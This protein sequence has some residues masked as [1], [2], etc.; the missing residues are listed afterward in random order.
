MTNLQTTLHTTIQLAATMPDP[1]ATILGI[2]AADPSRFGHGGASDG[3]PFRLDTTIDYWDTETGDVRGIRTRTGIYD[4]AATWAA[5]WWSWSDDRSPKPS[6]D[7]LQWLASHLAWAERCY[8]AMTEFEEELTYVL[9]VLEHAHGLDPIVTDRT[10]P[11]CGGQLQHHVTDA[12]VSPEYDC[13]GCGNQYSSDG[14]ALMASGRAKAAHE[15]VTQ[16]EAARLLQISKKT[17]HS[18]IRRGHLQSYGKQS[19]VY[20]DEVRQLAEQDACVTA[21]HSA[22]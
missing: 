13:A 6:G 10:C 2:R 21:H 22:D 7:T 12:G 15:L 20:I 5:S 9:R 4:W 11:S 17:I 18:W 3:L 19:A 14:L 16:Q 8:P 1:H